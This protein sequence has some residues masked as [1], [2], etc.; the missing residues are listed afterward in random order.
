M[1]ITEQ[2]VFAAMEAGG[3]EARA[4]GQFEN[5]DGKVMVH[6]TLRPD[7]DAKTAERHVLDDRA[8]AIGFVSFRVYKAAL[9]AALEAAEVKS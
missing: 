6:D 3:T 5:R 1:N 9:A 7:V 2:M 8:S 4:W